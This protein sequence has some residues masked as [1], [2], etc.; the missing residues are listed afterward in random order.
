MKR[1][2]D[3]PKTKRPRERLAMMGPA[4]LTDIELIALILGSG[5]K[6]EN[7]LE[8][9]SRFLQQ[10]PVSSFANLTTQHII[11]KTSL[12]EIQAGKMIAVI[13]LCK[14]MYSF[15]QNQTYILTPEDVCK[16]VVELTQK[17]QEYLVGL[18]LNA[19]HELLDKQIIA[20]GTL[21]QAVIEPRDILY[22]AIHLPASYIVL[23]HNHPSGDPTPSEEDKQIT[24]RIATACNLLGIILVDHII[25]SSR[26]YSSFRQ[27]QL[28]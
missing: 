15:S 27:K 22:H 9:S 19:R 18:Y 3:L 21:N 2:K 6:E 14:R 28:L 7:V 5:S 25:I 17:Q 12:G 23:V 1:I 20:V 26:G 16:Q 24:Q 8:R 10:F 11:D 13:E 4:N